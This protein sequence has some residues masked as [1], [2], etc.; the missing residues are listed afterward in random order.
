MLV[1]EFLLIFYGREAI[2]HHALSH[3]V[4]FYVLLQFLNG[5]K[6]FLLDFAPEIMFFVQGATRGPILFYFSVPEHLLYFIKLLGI[7]YTRWVVRILQGVNVQTRLQ[8]FWLPE[9]VI[10][11]RQ[12]LQLQK[13][14]QK[15]FQ[16]VLT[17]HFLSQKWDRGTL[18]ILVWEVAH[19]K[20]RLGHFP[21][22]DN[23]V[24][25]IQGLSLLRLISFEK[26]Q[27]YESL[28]KSDLLVRISSI[29]FKFLS[30]GVY[31]LEILDVSADL[32]RVLLPGK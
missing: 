25:M 4:L 24:L 9:D 13:M 20:K 10:G 12:R 19:G 28:G 14:L 15:V 11:L 27:F 29:N 21:I 31:G 16:L 23:R 7:Y 26:V 5:R 6:L 3:L 22:E 30:K 18:D 1:S 8:M 2:H 32:R 17:Q